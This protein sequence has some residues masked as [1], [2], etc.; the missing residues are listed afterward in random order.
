MH[1]SILGPRTP[2]ELVKDSTIYKGIVDHKESPLY[3]NNECI[4]IFSA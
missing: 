4:K 1:A 2:V 3:N